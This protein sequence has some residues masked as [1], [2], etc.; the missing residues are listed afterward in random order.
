MQ[1]LKPFQQFE[2]A[3]FKQYTRGELDIFE[4]EIGIIK[5]TGGTVKFEPG[6]W[7]GY[8]LS[9]LPDYST[10]RFTFRN[11]I[12]GLGH[13]GFKKTS[14]GPWILKDGIRYDSYPPTPEVWVHEIW[15]RFTQGALLWW[16]E[17]VSPPYSLQNPSKECPEII[18]DYGSKMNDLYVRAI[19][20]GY[21]AINGV[22]IHEALHEFVVNITNISSVKKLM[23]LGLWLEYF[24]CQKEWLEN[25]K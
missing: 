15:H 16:H 6:Y 22:S 21:S 3:V 8:L 11:D 24:D 10:T 2:S 4:Q 12:G 9:L 5:Y 1:Y 7:H 14:T 13:V 25:L 18:M 20:K 23:Q 17:S 19:R